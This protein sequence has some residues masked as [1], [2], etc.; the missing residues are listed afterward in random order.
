MRVNTLLQRIEIAFNF[1]IYGKG[2]AR[3]MSCGK[4]NSIAIV[5]ITKKPFE[6]S[7]IEN[8]KV[9]DVYWS[10]FNKC[11]KCGA[12]CKEVQMWNFAGDPAKL[13]DNITYEQ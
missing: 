6:S 5:P 4:C 2:K 7:Y 12:V 13:D 11:L 8:G 1:I 9:I 3:V 10:E